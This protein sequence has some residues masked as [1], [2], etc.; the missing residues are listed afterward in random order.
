MSSKEWKQYT[1]SNEIIKA[2]DLL[3]YKNPTKVQQ[4]V[5]PAIINKNDVI[6]KSQTGS[7]KTASFAI[8]ICEQIIWE[9]NKP[10]AIIIEPTRELALQVKEDI[11][12]IGRFK[13]I[14]PTAVYGRAPFINQVKELKQKTHVIVGTPGRIIDHLEKGTLDTSKI[15]YLVIDEADEMLRMGFIEQVAKIIESLPKKRV[16]LLLSATMPDNIE[17]LCKQYMKEPLFITMEDQN[18]TVDSIDQEAYIASE[19]EK[20]SLLKDIMI[21]NNPDS[22]I[23]FCNTQK[24]VDEVAYKMMKNHLSCNQIHGGMEQRDRTNVMEQFREGRFRYLIATDVAARGIDIDHISLVINYELPKDKENYV[25]RIGRTGRVN[26]EG[27]AI[28]LVE[29]R[30]MRLLQ[31]ICEYIDKEIPVREAPLREKV[32]EYKEAFLLKNGDKPELKEKK[33]S[34]LNNN[35]LKLHINA[36]KKAKIRPVDI[37]GSICSIEGVTAEDIGI[38]QI[39][40]ISTFVEILNGKGKYVL[41]ELLKKTIKGKVR[42]IRI[43]N[44]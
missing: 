30:D 10:Q 44:K 5:I 20:F 37:V 31:S 8:P 14:K 42:K 33:G 24:T 35:I 13:R 15:E 11:F 23:I 26:R 36:G 21:L 25:H 40:D 28:S 34:S 16:T 41:K 2:I 18:L 7:G 39:V 22:C 27:K 3:G 19:Q 1:L 43:S 17:S 12:H 32:L 29:D 38:I 4:Q 9:E 6:V